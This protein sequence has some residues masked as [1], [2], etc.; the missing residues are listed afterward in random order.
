[1]KKRLGLICIAVLIVI[2]FSICMIWIYRKMN[3]SILTL[4]EVA[5]MSD[6]EATSCLA[7]HTQKELYAAWGHPTMCLSG[8][9]GDSWSLPGDGWEKV[10]VYYALGYYGEPDD[11]PVTYVRTP[12][13]QESEDGEAETPTGVYSMTSIQEVPLYASFLNNE[14]AAVDVES[15]EEQY[16]SDYYDK[17]LD[18]S[19][20]V[21]HMKLEDM[22][23]DGEKELLIHIGQ[24]NLQ[25]KILVFH[26]E[27]GSL[28]EWEPI[29]YGLNSKEINLYNNQIIGIIGYG[30]V[31]SFFRY[32]DKGKL[33][34]VFD[35]SAEKNAQDIYTYIIQEY[36]NGVVTKGYFMTEVHGSNGGNDREVSEEQMGEEEFNRVLDDFL[37]QLGEGTRMCHIF[38]SEKEVIRIIRKYD[39]KDLREQTEDASVEE[40]QDIYSKLEADGW[41]ETRGYYYL[42]GRTAEEFVNFV[43]GEGAYE[44]EP[45]AAYVNPEGELQM[46]LWTNSDLWCGIRCAVTEEEKKNEEAYGFVINEKEN[47]TEIEQWRL[48]P[49]EA[50]TSVDDFTFLYGLL[51]ETNV[52]NI[53]GNCEYDG[54]GRLLSYEVTGDCIVHDY[55]TNQD[56]VRESEFF[57]SID[58][59]YY[60]NGM[61]EKIYSHSSRYFGTSGA[62]RRTIYDESNREV[63]LYD[64]VSG[65]MPLEEY[66]LYEGDSDIPFCMLI[67]DGGSGATG[68]AQLL[69][70]K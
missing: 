29:T 21:F 3:T 59:I 23:G 47:R 56:A 36:E 54:I 18:S 34:R 62:F 22:N 69:L 16:W 4:E 25:G 50:Y 8:M 52:Q 35:C 6:E 46:V 20:R 64:S 13:V 48:E 2:L 39:E 44:Q 30:W 26:N 45:Y 43:L 51:G 60:D 49:L 55:E 67:V 68:P 63:Y 10:I 27:E 38:D 58:Y 11:I 19:L 14:V 9:P 65:A 33:E 41:E 15:Q 70:K 57:Y 17:I 12:T 32:N 66:Y 37:N 40:G 61:I 28:V 7:G 53:Q 5:R 24:M 31:R 1:M 42:K